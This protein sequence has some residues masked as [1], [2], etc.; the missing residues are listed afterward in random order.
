MATFQV[1]EIGYNQLD[2]T[3]AQIRGM[4]MAK[5]I[6]ARYSKGRIELLEKVDLEEGEEIL[7]SILERPFSE[8][9]WK[10]LKGYAEQKAKE[11][12]ITS[13]EQINEL[14][15]EQRRRGNSI[16]EAPTSFADSNWERNIEKGTNEAGFTTEKQVNELIHNQRRG[17]S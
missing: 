4:S 2:T 9:R 5:A 10:A 14:I 8:E 12:G 17:T 15:H 3:T 6:R 11:K 16:K 13:E 7:I 1:K